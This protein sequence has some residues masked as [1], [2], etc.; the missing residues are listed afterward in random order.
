MMDALIRITSNGVHQTI[1]IWYTNH[2]GERALREIKPVRLRW[3]EVEWHPG[4][5]WLVDAFD[6]ERGAERTFALD[7]FDP[8]AGIEVVSKRPMAGG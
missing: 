5:R 6:W 3:G 4:A 2:R 8:A 7:G 1:R